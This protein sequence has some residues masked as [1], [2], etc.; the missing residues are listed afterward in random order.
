MIA[1]R[2]VACASTI[3]EMEKMEKE[4]AKVF[5]DFDRAINVETLRRIKDTGEA[6]SYPSR[7]ISF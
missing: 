3:E 6:S 2:V 1:A 5:K 7:H 4:L